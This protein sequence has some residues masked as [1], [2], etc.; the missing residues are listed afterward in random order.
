MPGGEWK[1]EMELGNREVMVLC[2]DQTVLIFFSPFFEDVVSSH[3]SPLP[4]VPQCP[5]PWDNNQKGTKEKGNNK[6]INMIRNKQNLLNE[7]QP[8]NHPTNKRPPL[9]NLHTTHPRKLNFPP[10]FQH[11]NPGSHL[12]HSNLADISQ[13]T[14]AGFR[15]GNVFRAMREE[16]MA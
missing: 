11:R 13:E 1:L 7:P 14:P 3:Y 2:F 4:P 15:V 16:E 6:T 5:P 8:I 10:T 12:R 9:T